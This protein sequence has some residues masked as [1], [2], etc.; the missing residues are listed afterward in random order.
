[1]YKLEK[2]GPMVDARVRMMSI[3]DTDAGHGISLRLEPEA[4]DT[5]CEMLN[6]A[7]ERGK[8]A[9]DSAR[10]E[11][12]SMGANMDD[13]SSMWTGPDGS[14]PK[15]LVESQGTLA[16]RTITLDGP[17][18]H[19]ITIAP[20]LELDAQLIEI[21]RALEGAFLAGFERGGGGRAVNAKREVKETQRVKVDIR[22]DGI[23]GE[24]SALDFAD[25]FRI[26]VKKAI[27]Q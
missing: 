12:I 25:A 18:V 27:E 13:R 8:E 6:E 10:F 16:K 20:H 19:G 4:E 17:G 9:G 23:D 11:L 15:Y 2:V 1:M 24:K 26:L 21:R 3:E 14:Y 7:Y 5:L 22:I